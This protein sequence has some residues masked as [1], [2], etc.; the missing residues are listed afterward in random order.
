MY[1]YREHEKPYFPSP[2]VLWKPQKDQVNIIFP[3][4]FWI[5][6][7]PYFPSAKSSKQELLSNQ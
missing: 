1:N 7:R 4:T 6:T 5:K 2:G 3:S